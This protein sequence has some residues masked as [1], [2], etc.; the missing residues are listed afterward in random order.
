MNLRELV[1][2]WQAQDAKCSEAFAHSL[3][4]INRELDAV[5]GYATT[6]PEMIRGKGYCRDYVRQSDVFGGGIVVVGEDGAG[7]HE[8]KIAPYLP[9]IGD[10]CHALETTWRAEA[11]KLSD[12]VKAIRAYIAKDGATIDDG[13]IGQLALKGCAPEHVAAALV[14]DDAGDRT[15]IVAW[16]RSFQAECVAGLSE[17]PLKLADAIERGEYLR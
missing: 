16:L 3:E 12:A 7:A 10:R 4:A 1:A 11:Y 15:K 9:E 14:A 2:F 6:S 17:A 13:I 8:G 5:G